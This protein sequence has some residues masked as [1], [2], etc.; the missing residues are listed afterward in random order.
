MPAGRIS[1]I[2][3][4]VGSLSVLAACG[5]GDGGGGPNGGPVITKASGNSGDGQGGTVAQPLADS[6]R[7]VVTQDGSAQAGVTVSWSTQ[8][9]GASV[10]PASVVT[11]AQ[12]RAATRM[13]AGTRSGAQ[14]ARAALAGGSGVNFGVT[15]A[16]GS[17]ANL[18]ISSGNNQ[19]A[20]INTAVQFPLKVQ[21]TDQFGNAVVGSP[22]AWSLASGSGNV[23]ASTPTDGAG[24]A[25][26][27]LTVGGTAEALV[28]R[29][30][31]SGNDTVQFTAHSV[32]V[33]EDVLVKNDFFESVTNGSAAPSVDTIS[34]GESIRWIWQS[35]NV[36]HNIIPQGSPLFQGITGSITSPF[37]FGPVYF[38]APGTYH[39]DCNLHSGMSGIIVVQ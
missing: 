31:S 33:V 3:T 25:A 36:D 13:T 20:L 32:T 37:T 28:I 19:A 9:Q 6:F 24:V 39:Y 12:G 29:A 7:V 10:S 14:G 4:L 23:V 26:T 35:G 27:A 21:V 22:V 30:V 18:T 2:G 5:G 15:I 1:T 34:V 38:G 16:A 8:A 17:P 11:D